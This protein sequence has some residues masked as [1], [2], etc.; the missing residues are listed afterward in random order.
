[1]RNRWQASETMFAVIK[2]QYLSNA[3]V[4]CVFSYSFIYIYIPEI[5]MF[6]CVFMCAF[7]ILTIFFHVNNAVY[8]LQERVL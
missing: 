8:H 7:K 2:H 5:V 4:P 6:L 1:M 3:L